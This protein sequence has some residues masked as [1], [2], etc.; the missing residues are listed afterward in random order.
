[1]DRE[2]VIDIKE[3]FY[4]IWKNI[5]VILLTFIISLLLGYCVAEF[6]IVPVYGASSEILVSTSKG[7]SITSTQA[8]AYSNML[9]DDEVLQTVTDNLGL[10]YTVESLR[11]KVTV[12]VNKS[13]AAITLRV[14]AYSSEEAKQILSEIIFVVPQ[15]MQKDLGEKKINLI[16]TPTF[17]KKPI[18]PD[19]L[20]YTL[21]SGLAGMFLSVLYVLYK[22]YKY[23]VFKSQSELIEELNLPILSSIPKVKNVSDG[24]LL[25]LDRTKCSSFVEAYNLLCV[26]LKCAIEQKCA[27]SKI[28]M[29]AGSQPM[30][31][32]TT[33]AIDLGSS[34]SK[35][36]HKVIVLDCSSTKGV[37]YKYLNLQENQPGL[38]D[39][40][41]GNASLKD[42]IMTKSD[43]GIDVLLSGSKHKEDCEII[44]GDNMRKLLESLSTHYDYVL[45]N[46]PPVNIVA[47]AS[48]VGRYV[49]AAILVVAQELTTKNNVLA[50]KAQLQNC[51]VRIIGTIF[52]MYDRDNVPWSEEK[53]TFSY[54]NIS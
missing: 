22:K 28:I 51:G 36:G 14:K 25:N 4:V 23:N 13:T 12:E 5:R 27:D 18:S 24:K 46:V 10:A 17:S 35:F 41:N 37:M 34:L 29:L 40:L 11:S 19:K 39:I 21:F 6:L 52:N 1:M 2:I 53:K 31:G 38:S 43:L 54:S 26:N 44:Y 16:S 20:K 47:D 48:A 15:K 45:C 49:D 50:A 30:E 9:V 8:Q 33:V 32:K 7:D 3:I 42:C